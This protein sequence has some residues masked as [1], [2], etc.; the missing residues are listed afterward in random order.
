MYCPHAFA[1]SFDTAPAKREVYQAPRFI[2][3][4]AEGESAGGIG[5]WESGWIW[6]WT[7]LRDFFFVIPGLGLCFTFFSL[8]FFH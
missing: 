6:I 7:G 3:Q 4:E 5:F 2:S 8:A 1:R